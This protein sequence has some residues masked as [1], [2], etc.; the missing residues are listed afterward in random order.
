MAN[1]QYTSYYIGDNDRGYTSYLDSF[2]PL[3]I[4]KNT[5]GRMYALAPTGQ[6][7]TTKSFQYTDGSTKYITSYIPMS[8]IRHEDPILVAQFI[9]MHYNIKTTD[10]DL[11]TIRTIRTYISN[12]TK[13]ITPKKDSYRYE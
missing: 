12:C 10:E 9:Q 4:A 2:I 7:I 6:G 13:K 8:V 11:R 1:V 5:N 3:L